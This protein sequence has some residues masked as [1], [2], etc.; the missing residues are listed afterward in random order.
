[1]LLVK[2]RRSVLAASAVTL[3][4]A[5]HNPKKLAVGRHLPRLQKWLKV[6]VTLGNHTACSSVLRVPVASSVLD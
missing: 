5:L 3:V 2:A 4:I 1:M 6:S